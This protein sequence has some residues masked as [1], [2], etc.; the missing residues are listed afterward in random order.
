MRV[1]DG[2]IDRYVLDVLERQA[3]SVSAP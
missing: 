3:S 2:K 1:V